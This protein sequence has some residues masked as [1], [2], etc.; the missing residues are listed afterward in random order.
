MLNQKAYS[1]LESWLETVDN[2]YVCTSVE[3]RF[4]SSSA[5]NATYYL[6]K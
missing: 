3:K 6:K 1:L 5:M 2:Y 4:N